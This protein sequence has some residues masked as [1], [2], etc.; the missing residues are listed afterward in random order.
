[1]FMRCGKS[2]QRQNH[3]S[4]LNVAISHYSNVEI[5][6]WYKNDQFEY[7]QPTLCKLPNLIDKTIIN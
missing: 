6:I 1:M 2:A 5:K 3:G 4:V 7:Q